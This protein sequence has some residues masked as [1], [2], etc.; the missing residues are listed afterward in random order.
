MAARTRAE[1]LAEL[2]ALQ[3]RMHHQE[4]A[5][6]RMESQLQAVQARLTTRR[7]SARRAALARYR[8][9][10]QHLFASAAALQLTEVGIIRAAAPGVHPVLGVG[11][12]QLEGRLLFDCVADED[13]K[14]LHA[15]LSR[16]PTDS[17]TESIGVTWVWP[18]RLALECRIYPW[19]DSGDVAWLMIFQVGQ[20]AGLRLA[21]AP[22]MAALFAH[23]LNQPLASLLAAAQACIRL[24]RER[25]GDR[26][27]QTALEDLVV[28]A[29]RAGEL[30]RRLRDFAKGARTARAPVDVHATLENVL[31][32]CRDT[33]RRHRIA[34]DTNWAEAA[35]LVQADATL[36][37]QA[38]SNL[39]RNAIEAMQAT[40]AGQ[41]RLTVVTRL[42]GAEL[43]IE[44]MDRG[45]GI[46]VEGVADLFEPF[47]STKPH[48]TGLG[49]ALTRAIIQAHGGRV[50]WK[51]H[52]GKGASFFVSLPLTP[53]ES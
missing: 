42:N 35:P 44:I 6:A 34:L 48:G 39:V 15:H 23:E 40:P 33:L 49:L 16:T 28:Q 53:Q 36:L 31:A 50:W 45:G 13:R 19:P 27:L 20:A 38:F 1:L 14:R 9:L 7:G 52:H 10:T 3:R 8:A 17:C 5:L 32:G 26:M 4:R 30:V 18:T 29:E 25:S 21:S 46:S 2:R 51:N 22:E 11:P 24:G 41:R 37:G 47:V 12:A 43:E